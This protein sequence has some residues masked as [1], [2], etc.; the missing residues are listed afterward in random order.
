MKNIIYRLI[1]TVIYFSFIVCLSSYD[2]LAINQIITDDD[3][4]GA[5]KT[6]TISIERHGGRLDVF[7]IVPYDIKRNQIRPTILYILMKL[8]QTYENGRIELYLIP[9][10]KV[11]GESFTYSSIFTGT[12][13]YREGV[14]IMITY[15]IPSNKQMKEYNSKIGKPI[16]DLFDNKPT[17]EINNNIPLHP[18][19]KKT[20]KIG[21]RVVLLWKKLIEKNNVM[22]LSDEHA[23]LISKE[24]EISIDEVDRYHTFMYRYYDVFG[25]DK[26]TIDLK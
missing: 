24:I 16:F 10:D 2:S 8:K 25:W 21:K 20:F 13:E 26:E 6:T 12:A 3:F 1:K 17:G 15:C 7:A 5:I 22:I 19:D 18:P 4:K 11:L 14:N 23:K 9:D